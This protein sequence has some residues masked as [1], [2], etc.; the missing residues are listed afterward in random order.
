MSNLTQFL[1]TGSLIAASAFKPKLPAGKSYV[2]YEKIP[3]NAP[4]FDR[5][6]LP[7]SANWSAIAW[8]GSVFCAVSGGSNNVAATSNSTKALDIFVEVNV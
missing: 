5:N 4:D 8:N 3:S 2:P 1:P 7:V 6:N